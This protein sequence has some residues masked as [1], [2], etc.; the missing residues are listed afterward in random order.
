MNPSFSFFSLRTCLLAL[1][2]AMPLL[3][4]RARASDFTQQVKLYYGWNAV[5]LQVA[6]QVDGKAETADKVFHST[7]FTIDSVASL[8]APGGTSEFS[9]DQ[10]TLIN[11]GGWDVWSLNPA[12]GETDNILVQ[13]NHAYLVHVKPSGSAA[14]GSLAGQLAVSGQALFHPLSLIK[15]NYNLIGFGIQGSPTFNSLLKPAGIQVDVTTGTP[16]NV[17]QLNPATG[18]WEGVPGN[19]VVEDG[20]AYWV[21]VPFG[22]AGKTY[23]GPVATTFQGAALGTLDCGPGPGSLIVAD[24][25]VSGGTLP[26]TREELTFSSLESS[27]GATHQV[28]LTRIADTANPGEL[29]VYPLEP[30]PKELIWRVAA[31]DLA[32]GWQAA[33]LTPAASTTVTLG[34][35]R[36]WTT[37]DKY[38]SQLYRIS[39]ALDGGAVWQ[40]L[41]VR[42]ANPDLPEAGAPDVAANQFAGLWVGQILVNSVT[43]LAV[44]GTPQQTTT[45]Q[46]PLTLL[47]HV[48]GSGTPS[49]LSHV[50]LMQT[51]SADPAVA[52][53]P[54]LVIHEARLNQF[55]GIQVRD[56]KKVGIRYET[57]CFDMPRDLRAAQQP[58][59]LLASI[60]KKL[61]YTDP[62]QVIDAD[63]NA[64]FGLNACSS[65]PPDLQEIYY[66]TWQ[67]EGKPGPGQT[68]GTGSTKPLT[69]D[70]YHRSNPF[71][72]AYHPQHGTGYS[73]TRSLS[74]TFDAA[75]NP[76][77]LT[78]TYQE[79][80]RGLARQDITSRGKIALRRVSTVANLQ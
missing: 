9:A 75:Y 10:A 63:V 61:D 5:W 64:Y 65:R 37:G 23:A 77:M 56:G 46:A 71:R 29:R 54:V 1:S 15:G 22:L 40:F 47:M 25:A 57:A 50:M 7:D 34:A 43:S 17:Q 51:K 73:I 74:I 70:P 33:S 19:A 45:S 24:P 59:S 76:G 53:D 44:A 78:G 68:V 66:R 36:N 26:V 48:D 6:P 42:A 12:S 69:L 67:L 2:V 30:V 3:S 32:S 31:G 4:L 35:N 38:R 49:L 79:I 39:V 72:H 18:G 21:N 16:Q 20:R 58:A 60:V 11:Q 13:A 52:P 8:I 27:G 14:I 55:V 41:P 62:S 28:T 80:T